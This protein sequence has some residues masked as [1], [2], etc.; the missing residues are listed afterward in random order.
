MFIAV[1]AACTMGASASW[2]GD[3]GARNRREARQDHR[4]L[5]QDRRQM[6]EDAL[7]VMQLQNLSSQLRAAA[8]EGDTKAIARVDAIV[9]RMLHQELKEG[10]REERQ[11]KRELRRDRR[12]VRS[13]RREIRENR[14]ENKRH[15]ERADDRRDLRD[16]RRDRR[17]DRR[18]AA[19]E[20][21]Q[22]D[23]REA[24]AAQWSSVVG[25]YD[26]GSMTQRAEL[27]DRLVGL[28]RTEVRQDGQ[29]RRE[30]RRELREDRRER[31]E[32]RREG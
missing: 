8:A 23:S 17:D 4:E 13:D 11:D 18:D 31:R 10:K 6:R 30:D 7:D 26:S 22:N 14:R 9:T 32:D 24:I 28:A 16:D 25:R 12:E 21:A 29:E 20:R 2:A 15:R 5:R 27:L 19:V 3:D 1:L